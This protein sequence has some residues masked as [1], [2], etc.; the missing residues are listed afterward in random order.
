MYQ[1]LACS[2][3]GQALSGEFFFSSVQS[4]VNHILLISTLLSVFV[5]SWSIVSCF[6]SFNKFK[7]CL[8]D[9]LDS[10]DSAGFAGQSTLL[11]HED[12]LNS[13]SETV[14]LNGRFGQRTTLQPSEPLIKFADTKRPSPFRSS[15]T[16]QSTELSMA[17]TASATSTTESPIIT[18]ATRNASDVATRNASDLLTCGKLRM[19]SSS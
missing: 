8:M 4:L 2:G 1:L 13:S 18:D 19:A 10:I 17:S 9:D 5:F 16:F 15:T 6:R 7:S 3:C 14:E 11:P 12:G